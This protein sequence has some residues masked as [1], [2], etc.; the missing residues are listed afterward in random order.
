MIDSKKDGALKK[1]EIPINPYA[2]LQTEAFIDE[3]NSARRH[4]LCTR[5]GISSGSPAWMQKAKLKEWARARLLP[6][7]GL[8]SAT[9]RECRRQL[10]RVQTV[11][12]DESSHGLTLQVK[13]GYQSVATNK[14]PTCC[15]AGG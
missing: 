11:L 13:Q 12:D 1:L 10:D 3:L 2:P 14:G 5:V 7:H 4:E 8:Q 6:P 9:F 15:K